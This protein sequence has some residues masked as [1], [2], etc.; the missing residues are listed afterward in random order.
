MTKVTK[1]VL[2]GML[3]PVPSGSIG[4]VCQ[5][6]CTPFVSCNFFFSLCSIEGFHML[7]CEP[8]TQDYRSLLQLFT[9]GFHIYCLT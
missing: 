2:L 1:A 3:S 6:L 8:I 7:F 9:V 5:R 4:N